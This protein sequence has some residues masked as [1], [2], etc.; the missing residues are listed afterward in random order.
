ME[1]GNEEGG[2]T[3]AHERTGQG[4]NSREGQGPGKY[5]ELHDPTEE[6]DAARRTLSNDRIDKDAGTGINNCPNGSERKTQRGPLN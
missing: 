1:D 3:I 4:K 2:S 6:A 5:L